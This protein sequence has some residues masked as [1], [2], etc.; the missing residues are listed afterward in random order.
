[1]SEI[2]ACFTAAGVPLVAPA[3]IP[4]IEIRRIDTQALVVTGSAMTEIGDGCFA[5]TFAPVSTLE[6][7][8]RADG[9]PLV[10]GQLSASERYQFGSLSG[11]TVDNIEVG[12]PMTLANQTTINTNVLANATL[13]GALNNLSIAGVQT[14]LT[15]QGYTTARAALLDKLVLIEQILRNKLITDPVTGVM[16]LFDDSDVALLTANLF[17]DAAGTIP[18]DGTGSE[19]RERLT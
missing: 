7:S 5:F 6:Y 11:I 19:R 9:D 4:T 14:A 1:M 18:Y 2:V 15:N 17:K 12:I 8:I 3:D 16:T 13:I 10:N